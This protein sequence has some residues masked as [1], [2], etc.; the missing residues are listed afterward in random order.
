M[1][2]K[3][4]EPRALPKNITYQGQVW[5]DYH[6]PLGEYHWLKISDQAGSVLFEIRDDR[7]DTKDILSFDLYKNSTAYEAIINILTE[8][9]I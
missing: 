8:L 7:T 2:D 3:D 4:K 1:I 9:R 5:R 6:I